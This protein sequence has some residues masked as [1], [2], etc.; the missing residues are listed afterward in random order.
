MSGAGEGR[1][2]LFQPVGE[3]AEPGPDPEEVAPGPAE[4]RGGAH[5]PAPVA[6]AAG[7]R[8]MRRTVSPVVVT[9]S[10]SPAVMAFASL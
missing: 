2:S 7:A 8:S 4:E 6:Q 10:P 3:I 1:R 5:Q 9:R